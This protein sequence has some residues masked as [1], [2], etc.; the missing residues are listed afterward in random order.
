MSAASNPAMDDLHRRI[1]RNLLRYQQIECALK[2]VLPYIHPQGGASGLEALKH[3]RTRIQSKPL[4]EAVRELEE[5]TDIPQGFFST[6]LKGVVD[7]R[8]EF[9]HHFFERPGID[10]LRP[11]AFAELSGYLDEQ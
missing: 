5:S 6:T 3:Y 11:T 7:A 1:G 9:V 4:G 8:N 2:F 10:L